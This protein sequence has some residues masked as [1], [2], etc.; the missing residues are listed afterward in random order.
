MFNDTTLIVAGDSFVYGQLGDDMVAESCHERSWVSKLGRIGNFKSVIN[1]GQPGGSNQR[2]IRVLMDYLDQNYSKE[3]LLI[4][5]GLTEVYRFE[6]PISDNST[7][8]ADEINMSPWI[9]CPYENKLS[10]QHSLISIGPWHVQQIEKTN[11]LN[12]FINTYYTYFSHDVYAEHILKQNLV[13]LNSLLESLNVEFYFTK[14]ILRSSFFKDCKI[15]N[16]KLPTLEYYS[17]TGRLCNIGEFLLASKFKVFPCGHFDHSAN[18]FV[19]GYIYKQL[20][21]KRT[22]NVAI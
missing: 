21:A 10:N 12:D 5:I 2:S 22:K 20:V 7:S 6:L 19:A 18:E 9:G 3:K 11:R 4:I 15:L 17:N 14:T 16:K 8:L 1:L 13:M